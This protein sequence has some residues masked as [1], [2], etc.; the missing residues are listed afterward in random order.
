MQRIGTFILFAGLYSA[1]AIAQYADSYV[2]SRDHPAIEYSKG[3]V[4][5][6][7]A[8]VNRKLQDGTLQLKFNGPSGYLR[9]ALDALNVPVESQVA[10]FAQN[11]S[12][13]PLIGM[14][15][16]RAVYFADAV[17]IG[18][19][20]G[21]KYLEVATHDPRQGVIFYTLDQTP[22]DAPQFKRDD[23]CLACHLSWNTRGVPGLFVVSMLTLPDDKNAY[24]SGFVSNHTT[25]FD[26]RWGGW[27]VTGNLGS[28]RHM[29]NVAV[30]TTTTPADAAARRVDSLEGR[31][32]L[33]G[34]PTPYSDVAALLVLEHQTHIT[35]LIT[36]LGWEARLEAYEAR[37]DPAPIPRA[38]AAAKGKTSRVENAVADLV[39]YAL[40]VY[41]TPLPDKIRGSSGFAEKFSALGPAD[42][43]GRS[44]RQLDLDRRLMRYP[45]SYMI[46]SDAFD[47]LPA[48]AKDQVYRRLWQVLSGQDK[49]ARYGVLS[50]AD[51]QAIVDI[52]RET[53]K[54]LPE[55][56][57]A[58]T[59]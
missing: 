33:T 14:K 45:C 30:S 43:K 19:V 23:Q 28:I 52:L 39:D 53:K 26:M 49:D 11:S 36:R 40:F 5:D 13:G 27:Y 46:Y 22:T 55:Y 3:P 31:F 1:A 56:F 35:N 59:R 21:G 29:A 34:Y 57:Q 51:R 32:D 17:A 58:V 47:A 9:S 10:V 54:D 20:R 12:Q 7:V 41:E 15:N 44:L 50:A 18:F 48:A 24:A 2:Q 42:G 8:A 25:S 6:R 16:P 38:P 4:T 37:T